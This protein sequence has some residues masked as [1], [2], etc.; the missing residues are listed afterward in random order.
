MEKLTLINKD[1]KKLL[2]SVS[3]SFDT[4]IIEIEGDMHA[5]MDE[6]R[7]YFTPFYEVLDDFVKNSPPEILL[8]WKITYHELGAIFIANDILNIFQNY[9]LNSEKNI[10][11]EWY[12]IED[13]VDIDTIKEEGENLAKKF[14]SLDFKVLPW[15]F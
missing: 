5:Y 2:P 6:F 10:K 7:E 15:F 4:G 8:T 3:V 11:V 1:P 12:Y 9:Q 14:P 13:L